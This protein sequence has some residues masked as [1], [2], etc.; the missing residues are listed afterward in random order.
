MGQ[1]LYRTY[2]SKKLSEIVGQEHITQALEQALKT[3]RIS[4]AYLFTGP[5]GI[6]KT[7]IARIL[8]HE[9]N[10]LP[11][12]DTAAPHLD[13][14][15][16]DAAS[17]RRIDEVR[18]LRDK[19]HIAPTAAKYKV[20]IID[21]VHML[22]KEAFNALLKTLEEPPAHA[23]FIL[24]TTEVH[25]LPE[26]IISRAQHFV[27][28][29]IETTKVVNHLKNIAKQEKIIID[30]EA[31]QLIAKHGGGSFRDSI[32]ILD[33]ARNH[34]TK[35]TVKEIETL[36]GIAPEAIIQQLTD[37]LEQ[38][39][40]KILVS[41][42]QDL[43]IQG[44]SSAALAQQISAVI[45]TQ[46]TSG[47]SNDTQKDITLLQTL[48]Q[49][50]VAPDPFAALEIAL[51]AYVLADNQAPPVAP[52]NVSVKPRAHK[53][54]AHIPAAEKEKV[55]TPEKPKQ[56]KEQEVKESKFEK[57]AITPKKVAQQTSNATVSE[58][59]M[60]L[61]PTVLTTVKKKYNTLYGV[62]RMA[63]PEFT[64]D[65]VTLKLS[66]SFHQKRLDDPKNKR[67]IAEAIEQYTKQPVKIVCVVEKN[68]KPQPQIVSE[69]LD[70]SNPPEKPENSPL[71]TISNIFG[72]AELLES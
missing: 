12:D 26:T 47:K 44:I 65:T 34:D 23:I 20:Y 71:G 53:P 10:D 6:G 19:I 15:E 18:D 51:L 31:L 56:T 63:E 38:R 61:W 55:E 70:V 3:N 66:F 14:I 52:A 33:Q 40:I 64:D 21:E 16:I 9:V 46:L 29:P 48:L 54:D 39:D 43:R 11:Y 5:R 68:V 24:A 17:N 72:G 35:I 57:P 67:I 50:P 7:S 59:S 22:T 37:A 62:L 30:D 45:R 60:S 13:I 36:L 4:H 58:L 42:L 49:V 25:K 32:S 69:E 1:A 41:L 2:R 28:K 27:F 8:A